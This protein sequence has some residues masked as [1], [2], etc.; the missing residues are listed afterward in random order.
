[1]SPQSITESPSR[2]ASF[3]S[4]QSQLSKAGPER[5]LRQKNSDSERGSLKEGKARSSASVY[6]DAQDGAS[7]H[8][9]GDTM[10]SK[11]ASVRSAM[12]RQLGQSDAAVRFGQ[13]VAAL[14]KNTKIARNMMP[15]VVRGG[16]MASVGMLLFGHFAP[17]AII[18]VM[19]GAVV[20][21]YAVAKFLQ[22]RQ[23]RAY[24]AMGEN[25]PLTLIKQNIPGDVNQADLDKLN[26][27]IRFVEHGD[28]FD[29]GMVKAFR[30][31]FRAVRKSISTAIGTLKAK[32]AELLAAQQA[33][34]TQPGGQ[35]P[36]LAEKQQAAS[37]AESGKSEAQAYRDDILR[38]NPDIKA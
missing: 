16:I 38:Q 30:E 4:A 3:H 11:S 2:P 33:G 18:G 34:A 12:P 5:S 27:I 36:V 1:M 15:M 17:F 22:V 32:R 8:S 35:G 31:P 13:D 19:A 9:S 28:V 10:V 26:T 24:A 37:I 21:G 14:A 7:A 29:A 25:N 23:A 20:G 6:L